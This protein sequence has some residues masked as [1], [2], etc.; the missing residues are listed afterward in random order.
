MGVL[1]VVDSVVGGLISRYFTA[2]L[3]IVA[4]GAVVGVVPQYSRKQS[5]VEDFVFSSSSFPSMGVLL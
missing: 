1:L 4:S 3:S 5:V 2:F